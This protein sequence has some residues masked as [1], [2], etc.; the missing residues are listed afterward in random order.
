MEN[1]LQITPASTQKLY[2]FNNNLAIPY[3]FLGKL[4]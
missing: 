1:V 3:D 2:Y 4:L